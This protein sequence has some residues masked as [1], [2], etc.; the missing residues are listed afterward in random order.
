MTKRERA[1]VVE[2]LRCAAD[3]DAWS[4][5]VVGLVQAQR[6]LGEPDARAAWHVSGIVVHERHLGG[7]TD[8]GFQGR[9]HDL[10]EAALRVEL[11]EWP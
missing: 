10:L 5:G 6:L 11:G 8:Q 2:L 9:R 4:N 7:G 3:Y 1:Q